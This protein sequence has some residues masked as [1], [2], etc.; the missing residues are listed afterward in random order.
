MLRQ[1]YA[2]MPI[3]FHMLSFTLILLRATLMML[4]ERCRDAHEDIT[5]LQRRRLL[6]HADVWLLR[7]CWL[8]CR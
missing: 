7:L 3:I 4:Y 8:R 2:D 1:D 6:R 5:A